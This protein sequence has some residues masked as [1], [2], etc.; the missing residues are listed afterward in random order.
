MGRC[1]LILRLPYP[2]DRAY[3]TSPG[4]DYMDIHTFPV[5]R[6]T[7]LIVNGNFFRCSGIHRESAVALAIFGWLVLLKS[8]TT[9]VE[10]GPLHGRSVER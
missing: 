10:N 1:G 4:S 7:E 9:R 5:Y 6:L 3:N 8:Y 2:V